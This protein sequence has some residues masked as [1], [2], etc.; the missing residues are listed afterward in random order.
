MAKLWQSNTNLVT[1][2]LDLDEL[3]DIV[4]IILK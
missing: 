2:T 3:E 1:H 4:L